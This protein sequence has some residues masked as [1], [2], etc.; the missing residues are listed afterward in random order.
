MRMLCLTI[1]FACLTGIAAAEPVAMRHTLKDGRVLDGVY[2]AAAGTIAMT[3][4]IKMS[5]KVAESDVVKSVPLPE[6]SGVE[7]KPKEKP[8]VEPLP[9]A[10]A[11]LRMTEANLSKQFEVAKEVERNAQS[12][13]DTAIEQMGKPGKDVTNFESYRKSKQ[14]L[15]EQYSKARTEAIDRRLESERRLSSVRAY[16]SCLEFPLPDNGWSEPKKLAWDPDDKREPME[17]AVAFRKEAD[18]LLIGSNPSTDPGSNRAFNELCYRYDCM[19]FMAAKLSRPA[20]NVIGQ[21]RNELEA[22]GELLTPLLKAQAALRAKPQ[23]ID[24]RLILLSY[25]L[26]DGLETQTINVSRRVMTKPGEY[27]IFTTTTVYRGV[28]FN[29]ETFTVSLGKTYSAIFSSSLYLTYAIL[30]RDTLQGYLTIPG[31]NRSVINIG[32]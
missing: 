9:A 4:A 10:I 8:L 26:S 30:K 5:I 12:N 16:R 21:T 27:E 3:G 13:V 24:R 15:V 31:Q 28:F 6:G 25:G 32:P 20:G 18:G 2:D 19:L 17:I 29:T 23:Q 14:A 22:A 1:T 7:D 11:H